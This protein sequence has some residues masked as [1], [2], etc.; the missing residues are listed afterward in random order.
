MP[1]FGNAGL[2]QDEISRAIAASVAK[3]VPLSIVNWRTLQTVY[4]RAAC[5]QQCAS[6]FDAEAAE[7]KSLEHLYTSMFAPPQEQ[8]PVGD[9]NALS[10]ASTAVSS[11]DATMG[12]DRQPVSLSTRPRD[13]V[14]FSSRSSLSGDDASVAVAASVELAMSLQ[15]GDV[16][17]VLDR[18]GCWN[19][20]VVLDVFAE[21][22]RYTKF[23]LVRLAL[24]SHEVV[25]WIGVSEG[26]LLPRGVAAG[27]MEFMLS[28][29]QFRGK[30]L[31]LTRQVADVLEQSFPQRRARLEAAAQKEAQFRTWLM[32]LEDGKALQKRKRRR[33]GGAGAVV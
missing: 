3:L 26:R 22:G 5:A 25:E 24:W 27:T 13:L 11:A 10:A 18:S 20:G 21:G 6:I 12:R 9:A 30:K 28:R 2:E 23:V 4:E 17:D 7:K 1:S 29:S 19:D 32:K 14:A 16:V 15:M 31:T 8:Q 33:V